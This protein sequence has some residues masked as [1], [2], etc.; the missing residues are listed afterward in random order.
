LAI[1][2]SLSVSMTFFAVSASDFEPII[3]TANGALDIAIR[4]SPLI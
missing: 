2:N 1:P 3:M 4:K